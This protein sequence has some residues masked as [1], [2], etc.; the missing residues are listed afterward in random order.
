MAPYGVVKAA[1]KIYVTNWAGA[2]PN[3]ND[4][5][6][7]GIPWGDAKVDPLTGATREGTVSAFNPADGR[8]IKEIIVGLHPNDIIT[9]PDENFVYVANANSDAVSV[10]DTKKDEIT[11]NIP[12]RLGEEKNPY[13]GDYTKRVHETNRIF[14]IALSKK[15]PRKN[16]PAV[17]VPAR[18]GEPSVFKH[19]VYIIKENRTYDQILGDVAAGDGDPSLCVFGKKVTP[20]THKIVDD[21]L[22]PDN[23]YVSG[24]SSAEGHQWTDM[25]IVTDNQLHFLCEATYPRQNS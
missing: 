8:L 1:G 20:N 9:S 11:E 17:P 12:V 16:A 19:V 21:F 14:R 23:F 15:L 25:A 22:L 7:A 24:K 6:V 5:N 18:I 2:V 13:W 4:K 10:I 3:E